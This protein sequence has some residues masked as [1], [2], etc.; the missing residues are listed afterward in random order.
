MPP[1]TS[2]RLWPSDV[3]TQRRSPSLV[4]GF[5]L[6]SAGGDE[7]GTPDGGALSK[8][9]V[10]RP[11]KETDLG[12]GSIINFWRRDASVISAFRKAWLAGYPCSPSSWSNSYQLAF[13]FAR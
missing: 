2:R 12:P 9:A 3:W 1:K 8:E 4:I 10:A 7:D 5:G 6:M 13:L 11:F